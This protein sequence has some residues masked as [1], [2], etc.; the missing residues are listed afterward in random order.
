MAENTFPSI[1]PSDLWHV[2]A[3]HIKSQP[4]NSRLSAILARHQLPCAL[5]DTLVEDGDIFGDGVNIAARLEGLAEPGGICVSARVHEDVAG[6]VELAFRDLGEQ[7]LKKSRARCGPMR[8]DPKVW[9]AYR[10]QTPLP[11][12]LLRLR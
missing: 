5:W 10:R 7:Q 1:L 3:R 12:L 2:M 11:P 4:D 8:G 9:P 6:K